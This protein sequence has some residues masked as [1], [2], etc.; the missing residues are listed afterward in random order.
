MS[1]A[2]RYPAWPTA[3][4]D[5]YADSGILITLRYWAKKPYKVLTV[6][7][8]VQTNLYELLEDEPAVEAAYPHQHHVFD[9]TSGSLRAAVTDGRDE[10]WTEADMP[11]GR[12]RS[13]RVRIPM[14]SGRVSARLGIRLVGDDFAVE[15]LANEL[16]ASGSSTSRRI[17]G[18]QRLACLLPMT[19]L[20][21]SCAATSPRI[22]SSISIPDRTT[23]RVRGRGRTPLDGAFELC[24]VDVVAIL[25]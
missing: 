17:I 3:Y 10:S 11:P 18:R 2:A 25:V 22:V 19:T 9:D 23:Y 24:P 16:F 14:N 8:E 21:A 20:S 4:I 13:R 6:R 7:S 15:F 12:R 5:E 1:V